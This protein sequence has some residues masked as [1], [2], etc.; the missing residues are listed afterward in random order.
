MRGHANKAGAP[1]PRRRSTTSGRKP[2]NPDAPRRPR[3]SGA[4]PRTGRHAWPRHRTAA[5]AGQCE[6]NPPRAAPA[7]A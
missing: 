6:W 2:R 3:R 7:T 4:S 5:T 1:A